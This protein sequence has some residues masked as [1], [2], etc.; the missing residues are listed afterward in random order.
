MSTLLVYA[1]A[2]E[3]AAVAGKHADTLELG[4]GKVAATRALTRALVESKPDAV[5]L[6]GVCGAYPDRHLRAGVEPV[7]VLGLCTVASEMLA[8]EGV[9]SPEGFRDIE[10]LQLGGIGP[11]AADAELTGKISAVLDCPAV[12]GATVSTCAGVDALSQAYALRSG[13]AVES[14]EGAAAAAVCESFSVP[15]AQLRAVS[16]HTGDR[17]MGAWNLEGAVSRLTQGLGA[18][19]DA[20]VLP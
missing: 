4:V 10:T 16:N 19:L 14:M 20:G 1:T 3:G 9:L 5:V 6:V 17:D 7:P 13:A 18:V 15:F 11:Y 2:R 12:S 8:D